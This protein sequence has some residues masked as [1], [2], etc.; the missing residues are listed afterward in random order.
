LKSFK[1]TGDDMG[2]DVGPWRSGNNRSSNYTL[3]EG[4]GAEIDHH[5]SI[6]ERVVDEPMTISLGANAGRTASTGMYGIAA[7]DLEPRPR[8]AGVPV[9]SA[10]LLRMPRDHFGLLD[11]TPSIRI[12]RQ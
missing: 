10:S 5:Y 7:V 8:R 9:K 11:Y 2:V 6:W 3:G 12:E 4:P 1:D